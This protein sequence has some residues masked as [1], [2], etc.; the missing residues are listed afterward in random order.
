M[1]TEDRPAW[2]IYTSGMGIL[3]VEDLSAKT[4]GIR[5]EKEYDDWD[6][7]H[8]LINLPDHA[9]HRNV[10]KI[11]LNA[12]QGS[13]KNFKTAIVC[14]PAIYGSGRG[15]GNTRSTQVYI[16]ASTVLKRGKGIQVGEGKNIWHE[17]HIQDLS[18][19]YL[20]LAEAAAVGGGRATWGNEG[21]YLVEDGSFVW[22]NVERLIDQSAYENGFIKTPELD[23]LGFEATAKE[24]PKGPYRWGSNSQGHAIRAKEL[25]GWEP[26]QPGLLE[27]LPQIVDVEAEQLQLEQRRFA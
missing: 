19:V 27:L 2:Y 6:G 14:P 8:E 3:T 9:F 12:T 5:R 21:Y 4:C 17:V 18:N 26:S 10:D 1:H 25:L 24:H 20:A 22:G 7:I 11:I 13:T 16:L 15:T 23:V